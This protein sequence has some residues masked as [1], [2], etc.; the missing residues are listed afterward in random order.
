MTGTNSLE[1]PLDIL[2]VAQPT[3]YGVAICLR[4]DLGIRRRAQAAK[5]ATA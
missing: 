5:A 4:I 3:E 1:R 2:I